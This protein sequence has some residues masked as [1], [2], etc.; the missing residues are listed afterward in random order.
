MRS[1][2]IRYSVYLTLNV[3][4][5]GLPLFNIFLW[6]LGSGARY[7]TAVLLVLAIAGLQFLA[8]AFSTPPDS[9]AP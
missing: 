4:G 6:G 7:A 1:E 9:P 8:A 2:P 3:G 5:A